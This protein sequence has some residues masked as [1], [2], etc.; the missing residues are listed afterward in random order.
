M[1]KRMSWIAIIGLLACAGCFEEEK[2]FQCETWCNADASDV[3]TQSYQATDE[4]DAAQQCFDVNP[5]CQP[6]RLRKCICEA[7]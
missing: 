1:K 4:S 3:T 6:G 7:L 5:D 2:P